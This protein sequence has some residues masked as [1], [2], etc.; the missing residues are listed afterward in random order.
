MTTS[1][2]LLYVAIVAGIAA[3]FKLLTSGRG[4]LSI[5]G[6]DMTWGK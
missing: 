1:S 5:P 4:R 2:L 6:I 3:I